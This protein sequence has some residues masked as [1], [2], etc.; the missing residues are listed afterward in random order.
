MVLTRTADEVST[1]ALTRGLEVGKKRTYI[2][3]NKL[4]LIDYVCFLSMIAL[5]FVTWGGSLYA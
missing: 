2:Y 1:S 5:I 4:N 3:T